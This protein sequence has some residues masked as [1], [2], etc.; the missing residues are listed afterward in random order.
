MENL[1]HGEPIRKRTTGWN[2]MG[3]SRDNQAQ[4]GL[5]VFFHSRQPARIEPES[6]TRTPTS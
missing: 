4:Q 5:H 1:D 2:N 3:G 6:I